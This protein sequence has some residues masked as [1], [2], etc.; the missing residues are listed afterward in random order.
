VEPYESMTVPLTN[1]QTETLRFLRV[2]D[3]GIGSDLPIPS[4]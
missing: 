2:T 3:C 1:A 4:F